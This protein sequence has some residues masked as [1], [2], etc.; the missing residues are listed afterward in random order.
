[1]GEIADGD[2]A[3]DH[4]VLLSSIDQ[5]F[6]ILEVLFDSSGVE[7]IDYRFLRV[8]PAFETMTGIPAADAL[9]GKTVLQ[10][11]PDLEKKWIKKYGEIA[12]TGEPARFEDGSDVMGRWF[13][14]YAFRVGDGNSRQ[15]ALLFSDITSQKRTERQLIGSDARLRLALDISKMSTFEIDLKTDA[16][17]TDEIG[18][19]IYGLASDEPLTFEKIQSHFHPDDK[20]EVLRAVAATLEPG[21]SNEFEVEQRIIRSNGDTRWIKVRGRTLFDDG[22]A[23]SMIGTYIDITE[24]KLAGHVR[25]QLTAQL[26]SE[27]ARL[28]YLFTNAP[29]FVATVRG[30]KHIFELTNPAYLRLIGH[31][32]VIGK[33]VREALPEVEGQGFFSILDRVYQSGEPFI[34]REMAI[35]LQREPNQPEVERFVDF[36]YQPILGPD[37]VATGIFAHGI[38]IKEQVEARKEAERANRAKD[39]FLATLSHELRT[40][41]GSILGWIAILGTEGVPEETKNKAIEIIQRNA[42]LQS[43]LI[44]DV[45]DVSRIISGKMRLNVQPVD[46]TSIVESAIES[47]TP[48]AEAKGIRLRKMLD[49]KASLISGDPNRLQQIIWNLLSNAVKFTPKAGRVDVRL[50]RVD[51]HVEVMV[52]D[53]GIGILPDSIP[54]IFERFT[55][56]DSGASRN[57]GGLGLG[58][59]IVRHLVEMHGGTVR[60]ESQGENTGAAFFVSLPLVPVHQKV[61][62]EE[63]GKTL[64]NETAVQEFECI[65]ELEGLHIL[66]VEDDPDGRSMIVTVL[67]KCGAKVTA[68]ASAAEALAA[69]KALIPDVLLSDIGMPG[70]D[71]FSLIA[72]IRALSKKDGGEIPAAALT[73]YAN[74]GDRLR[75]LRAGFQIHLPKPIELN[76][77]IAVVA[78]LAKR[79]S[80]R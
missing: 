11:I 53:T 19:N 18:R 68:A 40:P 56:A 48:A 20:D 8:N 3:A 61:P 75:A 2:F 41:L 74:A 60:A 10:I 38:D 63:K 79:V 57:H 65:P 39:E 34:G 16:V 70:E 55:Q 30:P 17:V 59:A 42:R 23:V 80:N 72:K 37:G 58:L 14:V 36:V 69:F 4:N 66:V 46:L 67:K 6:C 22:N 29:A 15:V 64:K 13:S 24:L 45:L 44:E 1:M 28:Q 9:S 78:T 51:S 32:N 27:R 52:A 21:N 12:L 50:H 62:G 47:I 33:T 77:L 31:R 7:P 25:E 49:S 76:E 35:M 5:G 43:E 71:G 73:A 26:E 54:H